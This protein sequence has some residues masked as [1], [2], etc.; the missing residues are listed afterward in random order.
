MTSRQT[1]TETGTIQLTSPDFSDGEPIPAQFT[2][3]GAAASPAL[4]WSNL[5]GGCKSVALIVDDPDAPDPAA[6]QRTFVHWVLYDIP[7][8]ADGLPRA[9]TRDTLPVGARIGNNDTHK[10]GWYPPCPPIG[11]HRYFFKIYALD[12]PLGA[13][14]DPTK[15]ALEK[16]MEG[17]IL[18]KGVL[19]GTYE[20][21]QK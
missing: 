10:P 11:R 7:V 3:E 13:L 18:D 9:A 12:E 21:Q 1:R 17:H 14:A 4:A 15:A 19:V 5:P 2:C 6:P 20:K 16:A 8:S